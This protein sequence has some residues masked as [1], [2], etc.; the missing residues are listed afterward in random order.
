MKIKIF[1][2]SQ[3]GL[4]KP[5]YVELPNSHDFLFWFESWNNSLNFAL[6]WIKKQK[7]LKN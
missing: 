1:K 6:F 4:H 2:S 7:D 3:Q 5:W